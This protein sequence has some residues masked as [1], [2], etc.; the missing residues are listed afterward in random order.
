MALI[1]KIFSTFYIKQ[2]FLFTSK[3]LTSF[4][5]ICIIAKISEAFFTLLLKI[6]PKF[7]TLQFMV[8]AFKLK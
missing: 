2:N 5:D 4:G 8:Q 1:M 7:I 6:Y 3:T